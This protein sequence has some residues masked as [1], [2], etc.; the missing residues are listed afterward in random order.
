MNKYHGVIN[1][2]GYTMTDYNL[3]EGNVLEIRQF[4]AE[5]GACDVM[6]DKVY[7]TVEDLIKFADEIRAK[8][9]KQETKQYEFG[10]HAVGDDRLDKEF[11]EIMSKLK[12]DRLERF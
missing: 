6:S 4:D 5:D 9:V 7:I 8:Y 12:E 10:S 3:L 2:D 11:E 1:Y